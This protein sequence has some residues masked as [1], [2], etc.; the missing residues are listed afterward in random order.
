MLTLNKNKTC[1][2]PFSLSNLQF[3][4]QEQ[5]VSTGPEPC[6]SKLSVSGTE[7][8][9]LTSTGQSLIVES[10]SSA[11][12]KSGSQFPDNWISSP[13]PGSQ[14]FWFW[15]PV[16]VQFLDFSIS[17]PCPGTGS[18]ILLWV[19]IPVP[20]FRDRDRGIPGLCLGRRPLL[21]TTY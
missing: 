11:S 4:S 8:R 3:L 20:D 18:R 9:I 15:V 13:R 17:R 16:P 19:P 6:P 21:R 2:V 5:G 7:V 1:L 10:R 12:H 14:I